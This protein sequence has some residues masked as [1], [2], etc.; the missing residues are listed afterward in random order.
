VYSL[1]AN[2]QSL[3]ARTKP[4]HCAIEALVLLGRAKAV[5][6]KFPDISA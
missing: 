5:S 4:L 3:F 2:Q 6:I 1:K